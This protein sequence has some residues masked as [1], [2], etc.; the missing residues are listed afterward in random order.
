ANCTWILLSNESPLLVV[1]ERVERGHPSLSVPKKPDQKAKEMPNSYCPGQGPPPQ[2]DSPPP[3]RYKR[4]AQ[5]ASLACPLVLPA[6]PAGSLP[7]GKLACI[8]C[9]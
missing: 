4:T 8:C 1:G 5:G 6:L 2:P 7:Y 3:G 9:S